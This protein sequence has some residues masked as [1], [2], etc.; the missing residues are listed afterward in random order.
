MLVR[1]GAR[2]ARGTRSGSPGLDGSGRTPGR[3]GA[4]ARPRTGAAAEQP[5]DETQHAGACRLRRLGQ[6]RLPGAKA[7]ID[8][9]RPTRL[10]RRR[11]TADEA[12]R[13]RGGGA[14]AVPELA[15]AHA[16]REHHEH[17]A[18][19][20]SDQRIKRL[21]ERPLEAVQQKIADIPAEP[22]PV[23]PLFGQ[24]PGRQVRRA[25]Q[26]RERQGDHRQPWPAQR[27]AEDQPQAPQRQHRRDDPGGQPDR[28]LG[29]VG[30]VG[31][32]LAERIGA[33]AAGG[34]V[35]R[36]IVQVVA[37]Q[38]QSQRERH[39]EQT[40]AEELDARGGASRSRRHPPQNGKSTARP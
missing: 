33:R 22:D 10:R 19:H 35:E 36:G 2:P 15:P 14:R 1:A 23:R 17:H 7:P 8:R 27:P 18:G 38:R 32:E 21:P 31:A 11:T 5:A 28:L 34:V 25:G 12:P 16:D 40:D 3:R 13:G 6:A 4:P 24:R 9:L 39:G 29:H 37:P 30:E 20:A 26:Q